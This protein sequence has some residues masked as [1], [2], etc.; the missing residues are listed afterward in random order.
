MTENTNLQQL[1]IEGIQDRKGR[2]I[3]IVDMSAIEGTSTSK[4]I[5]AEGTSTMHVA[6]VA[7]SVNDYVRINGSIKPFNADGVEGSDWI[8]LDYGEIWVHIFMPET[9]TRYSLEDLWNDARIASIPDV[10]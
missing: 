8:V 7:E 2:N 1:I 10:D 3:V 6:A 5:I 4:F 9:R